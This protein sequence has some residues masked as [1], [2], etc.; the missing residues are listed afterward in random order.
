MM[1]DVETISVIIGVVTVVAGV[2]YSSLQIRE[3][4]RT[5]HA[6]FVMS[7]STAYGTEEMVKAL[8]NVMNLEFK[9]VDDFARKY[10]NI[11]AENPIY[12]SIMMVGD[13]F[14]GIGFLVHK[15]MLDVN[16]VTELL[17]VQ[18]WEKIKPVIYGYRKKMNQPHIFQWF[19][20]LYDEMKKRE[21][22]LNARY[23]RSQ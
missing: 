7:V 19:E 9:D 23:I 17:P 11:S 22:K 14:Q 10:G 18:I 8:I 20:Y 6:D 13:Y 21:Q 5:R 3:Q 16:V 2:V 15:K 1:V 4:T 12:V